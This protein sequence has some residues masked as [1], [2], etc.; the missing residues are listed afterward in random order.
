MLSCCE[1]QTESHELAAE[2]IWQQGAGTKDVSQKV[3]LLHRA[4]L[5]LEMGKLRE[6]GNLWSAVSMPRLAT[7]AL[8]PARCWAVV[9]G[10]IANFQLGTA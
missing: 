3:V 7:R 5:R 10:A 2:D 9:T 4:A 1:I 8:R 6:R